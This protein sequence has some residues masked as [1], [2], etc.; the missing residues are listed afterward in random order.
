MRGSGGCTAVTIVGD[1]QTAAS[2]AV[3]AIELDLRAQS[4]PFR[5]SVGSDRHK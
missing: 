3:D 2:Q 4:W 5:A 1:S